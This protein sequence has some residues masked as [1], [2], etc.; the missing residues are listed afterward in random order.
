MFSSHTH[1]PQESEFQETASDRS[2]DREAADGRLSGMEKTGGSSSLFFFTCPMYVILKRSKWLFF[3]FVFA[4]VFLNR[5][6]HV[7]YKKVQYC[8][9]V[10]H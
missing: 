9:R 4:F 3:T 2:D 6:E 1:T 8:V 10:Y 5:E 7:Y